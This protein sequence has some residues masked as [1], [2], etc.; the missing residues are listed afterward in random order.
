[1]LFISGMYILSLFCFEA[2]A[3]CILNKKPLLQIFSVCVFPQS[4]SEQGLTVI[5]VT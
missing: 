4:Y 2:C 3:V 5:S 1:M